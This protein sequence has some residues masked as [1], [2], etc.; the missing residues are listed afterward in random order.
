MER[1]K[2]ET[3]IL[4]VQSV[5]SID[6]RIITAAVLNEEPLIMKLENVLSDEECKALITSAAPRLKR[7]RLA[8]KEVSPIRTSS[9]MFFDENE[10][11]FIDEMEKRISSLMHVPVSH[12]EGLQVLHYQPGQEFKEHVDFFGPNHPSSKNNRI[13]TLVMYLNDVEEGGETTFPYLGISVKPAKG[14]AVYFEYFYS[15]PKLNELTL[16]CSE[17]V[18][19][20]EKWVATQWMRRQQIRERVSPTVH[21]WTSSWSSSA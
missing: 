14:S 17:P 16:H 20:G 2:T 21:T 8:N 10:S 3:S 4:P 19:R 5:Y 12:A 13:S 6:G 9:G 1:M 15:N 7:S 18:I 11:P